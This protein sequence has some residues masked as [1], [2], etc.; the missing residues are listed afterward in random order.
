MLKFI[1]ESRPLYCV[2]SVNISTVKRVPALN[3]L[4]F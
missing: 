3:R 4:N 1:T 2:L